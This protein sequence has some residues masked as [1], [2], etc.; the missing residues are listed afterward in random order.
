MEEEKIKK[1]LN[2]RFQKQATNKGPYC[3]FD[4]KWFSHHGIASCLL[5]HGLLFGPPLFVIFLQH[6]APLT[7][8]SPSCGGAALARR[9]RAEIF[10]I[11]SR[12]VARSP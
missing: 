11:T 7:P 5:Y 4:T 1:L 2:R 3:C 6:L 12:I 8:L 10:V 9:F